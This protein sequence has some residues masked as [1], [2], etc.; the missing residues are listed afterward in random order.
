MKISTPFLAAL[1]AAPLM[2]CCALP[3]ALAQTAA[4]PTTIS[5]QGFFEI[6]RPYLEVTIA[7]VVTGVLGWLAAIIQKYLGVN[8][9]AKHR[10]ALHSAVMTGVTSALSRLNA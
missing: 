8:I 9:E 4:S 3:M 2:L 10:E 7:A 5:G 6:V 1:A